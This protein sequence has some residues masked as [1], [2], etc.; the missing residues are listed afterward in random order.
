[1][2]GIL[3]RSD[4]Y[5]SVKLEAMRELDPRRDSPPSASVG[6]RAPA[7]AGV[8]PQGDHVR[9]GKPGRIDPQPPRWGVP[10]HE[11]VREEPAGLGRGERRSRGTMRTAPMAR[12]VIEFPTLQ[13]A[14]GTGIAGSRPSEA[15]RWNPRC[16]C[17]TS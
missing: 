3:A 9:G 16:I 12:G 14:P 11:R 2:S 13:P 7:G 10:P 5:D 15:F 1:M 8:C 17:T 4:K 6:T